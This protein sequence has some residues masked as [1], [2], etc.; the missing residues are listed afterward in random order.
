MHMNTFLKICAVSEKIIYSRI[1]ENKFENETKKENYLHALFIVASLHFDKR[2][3][4]IL[5]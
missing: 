5:S 3:P 4:R 2:N 1:R